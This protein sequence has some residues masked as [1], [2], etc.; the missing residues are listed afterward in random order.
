MN[1]NKMENGFSR[2]S[3]F[4][5]SNEVTRIVFSLFAF[6][7]VHSRLIILARGCGE[8]ALRNLWIS[9]FV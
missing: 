3:A 6:L 4:L 5:A 8:G 1:T 9:K 2:L 7:R